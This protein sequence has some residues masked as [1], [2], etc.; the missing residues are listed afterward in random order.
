MIDYILTSI[1]I[2]LVIGIPF[3]LSKFED[4]NS[5]LQ[6]IYFSWFCWPVVVL[7]HMK[8]KLGKLEWMWKKYVHY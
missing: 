8:E 2:Y 5:S 4:I 7:R 3:M 1:F 6:K